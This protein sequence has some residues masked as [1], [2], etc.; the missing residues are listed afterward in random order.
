MQAWGELLQHGQDGGQTSCPFLAE[1]FNHAINQET[2]EGN[3]KVFLNQFQWITIILLEIK[4]V[5]PQ[6]K[7]PVLVW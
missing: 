6:E 1:Q 7:D 5:F 4:P 3:V 2:W